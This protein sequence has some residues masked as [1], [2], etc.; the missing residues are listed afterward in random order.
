ML[1]AVLGKWDKHWNNSRSVP[2]RSSKSGFSGEGQW[3]SKLSRDNVIDK[4][5][6]GVQKRELEV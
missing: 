3:V 5:H 6:R 4:C 2:S 1:G